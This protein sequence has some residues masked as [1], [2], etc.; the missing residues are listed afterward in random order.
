MVGFG[1]ISHDSLPLGSN[2]VPRELRR[3]GVVNATVSDMPRNKTSEDYVLAPARWRPAGH[4]GASQSDGDLR[5]ASMA[6]YAHL[7]ALTG[8]NGKPETISQGRRS[9]L[10]LRKAINLNPHAELRHA[11]PA[12]R[13]PTSF[14][15]R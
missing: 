6:T 15:E 11:D 2:H 13:W 8:L 4:A 12:T 1:I 5:Q 10:C 9:H 14:G 7:P 3:V